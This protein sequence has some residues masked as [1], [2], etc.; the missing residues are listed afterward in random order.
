MLQDFSQLL[1][2]FFNRNKDVVSRL[3]GDEFAVFVGRKITVT[4]AEA[5]LTKFVS[6]V[7]KNLNEKYPA[8]NL[9]A[10]IGAAFVSHSESYNFLYQNADKALYEIKRNGKNGFRIR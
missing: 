5:M 4:E 9:S 7:H 6:L 1:E 3:G 8:Q 2:N 10:S